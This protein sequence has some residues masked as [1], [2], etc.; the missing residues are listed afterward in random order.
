MIAKE[1]VDAIIVGAVRRI[2]LCRRAGEAGQK[3]VCA[4]QGPDWNPR[5]LISSDFGAGGSRL[6]APLSC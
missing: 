1:K 6:R 4:Q 3:V 2:G 5:N